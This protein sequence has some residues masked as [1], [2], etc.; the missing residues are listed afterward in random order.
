M[1]LSSSPDGRLSRGR[2]RDTVILCSRLLEEH[3]FCECE[4]CFA[5]LEARREIHTLCS[6]F[7]VLPRFSADR[8]VLSFCHTELIKRIEHYIKTN[9]SQSRV[10]NSSSVFF[11][12]F[13]PQTEL[14]LWSLENQPVAKQ[15]AAAFKVLQYT[16]ID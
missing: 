9:Y 1:Q 15:L 12:F 3:Q 7:L 8:T 2:V 14:K 13:S 5:R 10:T 6:K 11:F 4:L 16:I